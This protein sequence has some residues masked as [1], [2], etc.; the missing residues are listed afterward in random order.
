MFH[1]GRVLFKEVV[2]HE[3]RKWELKTRPVY[4]CR[5]DER[6]KIQDEKSTRLA[7]LEHLKT[8]T[9]LVDEMFESVMGENVFFF[10]KIFFV[11]VYLQ[12]NKFKNLF[13]KKNLFFL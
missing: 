6:L 4:E 1:L 5:Y 10:F 8:K 2:Y 3:L 12:Q 7:E 9:R 11:V 13:Y